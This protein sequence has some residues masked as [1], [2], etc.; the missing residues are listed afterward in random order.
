MLREIPLPKVEFF[1]LEPYGYW[2]HQGKGWLPTVDDLEAVQ[3]GLKEFE[4]PLQHRSRVSDRLIKPEFHDE[5]VLPRVMVVW[6][7][8][9]QRKAYLTLFPRDLDVL[10]GGLERSESYVT[11][12]DLVD[13]VWRLRFDWVSAS[14]MARHKARR[15]HDPDDLAAYEWACKTW[16][17]AR[18]A[19]GGAKTARVAMNQTREELSHASAE[20]LAFVEMAK[21]RLVEVEIPTR[22][23]L[24]DSG[25]IWLY[26]GRLFS[27][28]SDD[29]EPDEVKAVV[30]ARDVRKRRTIERAKEVASLDPVASPSK[31]SR[32][33]IPDDVKVFVWQRDGGVCVKC[34]SN[35]NLEFDHII[36]VASGGAN[37]ARNLQ[38]LCESCNREKGA[39][40]A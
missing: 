7:T 35:R 26:K 12:E 23:G 17:G 30:D 22:L 4:P 6:Q 25:A 2:E 15:R 28:S 32:K 34:G 10:L 14:I 39:N 21:E 11:G 13:R 40:L 1:A 37:T 38:I 31:K 8:S 36:P 5:S 19:I 20:L 16:S 3:E 29:L 33:A 18:S 9:A 24:A 27:N